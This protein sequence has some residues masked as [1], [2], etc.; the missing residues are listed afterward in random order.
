MYLRYVHVALVNVC[1][2]R[3]RVQVFDLRTIGI[4]HDSSVLAVADAENFI[5]RLA[6][7][8]FHHG[9]IKFAAAHKVDGRA[10]IQCAIRRRGHRR[11]DKCNVDTGSR[12]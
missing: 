12:A 4:V 1:D 2:P 9:E 6:V 7:G 3:H 10:L 8:K 11:P 5:E